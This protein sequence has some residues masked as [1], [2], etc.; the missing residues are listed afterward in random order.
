MKACSE[1]NVVSLQVA[2]GM[3]FCF[4][5]T[6]LIRLSF[7]NTG[8]RLPFSLGMYRCVLG[9]SESV[10][11]ILQ[12]FGG[13]QNKSILFCPATEVNWEVWHRFHKPFWVFTERKEEKH[14]ALWLPMSNAGESHIATCAAQGPAA[15]G[16][17]ACAHSGVV[18]DY[19]YDGIV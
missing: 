8:L 9:W 11:S 15:Q 18:R 14:S 4:G 3:L 7:C 6:D 16:P 17:A 13:I 1:T 12:H 19:R 5:T 2:A 10:G